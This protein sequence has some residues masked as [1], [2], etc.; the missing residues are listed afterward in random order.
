MHLS[1]A[2]TADLPSAALWLS[3]VISTLAPG[4][5]GDQDPCWQRV[6]LLAGSTV[7]GGESDSRACSIG[8][9]ASLAPTASKAALGR[10]IAG[11][12][13]A[14]HKT[15]RPRPQSYACE[16]PHAEQSATPSPPDVGLV[17]QPQFVAAI[18]RI[19]MWRRSYGWHTK[20]RAPTERLDVASLVRAAVDDGLPADARSID[21][22]ERMLGSVKG[23]CRSRRPGA[24]DSGHG[25]RGDWD[26][27][28]KHDHEGVETGEVTHF[29][30]PRTFL[31]VGQLDQ[32]R[33]T[34]GVH[35]DRYRSFELYRR[36]LHEPENVSEATSSARPLPRRRAT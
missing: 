2:I 26:R 6:R 33:R 12:W 14:R 11:N 18:S 9:V 3:R 7:V 25:R 15:F 24:E 27:L 1:A 5:G 31:I 30:R 32:L 29:V 28:R 21:V 20:P 22:S 19:G 34:G 36:S 8:S 17:T 16:R 13:T 35:L 23:A 4:A 10:P